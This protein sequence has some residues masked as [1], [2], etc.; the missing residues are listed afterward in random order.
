[1]LGSGQFS[2]VFK[3]KWKPY[4]T[5]VAVKVAKPA[6]E[7]DFFKEI[8]SEVKI[9]IYIGK[10]EHVIRLYGVSTAEIRDSKCSC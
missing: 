3:G 4:A 2:T 7:V 9:M 5:L 1:V 8:L 6:T 10:A